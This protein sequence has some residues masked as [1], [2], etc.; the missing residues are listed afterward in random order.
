MIVT[1][2]MDYL[3][4]PS[5]RLGNDDYHFVFWI[6]IGHAGT[7]ISA[8]LFLSVKSGEL[9]ARSAEAMTVLR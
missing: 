2:G 4:E 9:G 6:G 5:D 7:L 8:I 1:T 3:G